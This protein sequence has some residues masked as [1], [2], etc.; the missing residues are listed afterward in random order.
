MADVTKKSAKI[1]FKQ[2]TIDQLT[3]EMAVLK[4]LKFAAKSESFNAEQRSL[5][6]ETIEADL[7]AL[8][9]E[10]EQQRPTPARGVRQA[11]Q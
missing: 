7:E 11:G 9:R 8:A 2:A 3:Y 1:V 4:R 6:E 10:L 5:L